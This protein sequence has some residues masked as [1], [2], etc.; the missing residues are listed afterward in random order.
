[1]AD[2]FVM[3]STGEGFGIAFLEAMA[4][5][6]RV[7]AGNRDGSLDPLVDGALGTV[8]DPEDDNQ[9]T[10]A[11]CTVLSTAPAIVEHGKRFNVQSFGQQLQA[12]VSSNFAAR[13]HPAWR[14]GPKGFGQ[15]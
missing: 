2:V 12:L 4:S 9:L 7:I 14:L 8:I 15:R 6:I 10:S 1:L 11:I 13:L 5:G 3:P